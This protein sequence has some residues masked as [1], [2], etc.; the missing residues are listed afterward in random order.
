VQQ[1]KW[2]GPSFSPEI[3]QGIWPNTFRMR[4]QTLGLLGLGKS[5]RSL[6]PKAQG[7]GLRVIAY[8]PYVPAKVAKDLNVEP[9]DLDQ[10]LKESDYISIHAPSI[11]ATHHM[12]GLEQFKKMKRT[13]YIANTARGS[14]IDEQA[15]IIALREGYIAGAGLD[16]LETEPPDPN[17]PLLKMDNVIVTAHSAHNSMESRADALRIPSEEALRVLRGEWPLSMLN[18]AVK[19]KYIQRWG[20]GGL[21]T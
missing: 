7:F 12:L 2:G 21:L 8:D 9:V 1:G 20:A 19:D 16:V 13:A 4:G 5:G 3:V 14:I 17:N 18:P 6:I 10:L 11:P 15:L